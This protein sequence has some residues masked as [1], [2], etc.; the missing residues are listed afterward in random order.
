MKTEHQDGDS[1][2]VQ[3]YVFLS[4][5]FFLFSFF[6]TLFNV[7]LS[8]QQKVQPQPK[9]APKNHQQIKTH[10]MME[11]VMKTIITITITGIQHHPT[12]QHPLF[13]PTGANEEILLREA[14]LNN[15]NN[16]NHLLYSYQLYF[17]ILIIMNFILFVY[18]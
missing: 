9:G 4:L 3:S 5:S 12:N 6:L 13:Q 15:N 2:D 11:T 1:D 10:K 7:V 16:H 14:N 17:I 18:H 8:R